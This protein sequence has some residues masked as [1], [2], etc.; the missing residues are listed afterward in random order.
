[1]KFIDTVTLTDFDAS[2]PIW[3]S[4]EG[5]TLDLSFEARI[6]PIA[7]RKRKPTLWRYREAIPVHEQTSVISVDEGY[8]PLVFLPIAGKKVGIK[9][10]QLFTTGSYKDRGATVLMSFIRG[11]G[12]QKI[13]QDSSGNAGCAVAAYAAMANIHCTIYLQKETS[14]SKV[15]QIKAYG[16]EIQF[17]DG[18]REDV[19]EAVMIAAQ[20]H[21]YA[22][23]SWNPLFFHGTKTFAYEVCEQ[24]GWKAPD[25][26]V[27]PAGNG[28]LIIGCYIGF[29]DLLKAGIISK[30]P[31]LIAVQSANC[32]P[33]AQAFHNKQQTYSSIKTEPTLAEG[34]AIKKPVR[35]NQILQMVKESGGDFISVTEDEI[36]AAWKECAQKG[37][38]IEPTSAATIAGLQK[39]I[40]GFPD[41]TIISL[42]SGNGL[43][44]TDTILKLI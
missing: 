43:K 8:T 13:V 10:E 18:T 39:Y 28:T 27:L 17:I 30:M 14:P 35:G 16:A 41:E 31:K 40:P 32:A 38:F 42:F 36:K 22:S 6:D 25:A 4:P 3:Q 5:H 23:H 12:I 44:S 26:V 7:I 21:Y 20:Q 24:L 1:M 11:L 2:I 34:I 19:A 37:H 15:A 29:T 33:L 9:Q